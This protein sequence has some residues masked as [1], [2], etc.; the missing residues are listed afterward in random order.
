M[1]GPLARIA[2]SLL[3]ALLPLSPAAAPPD[4]LL[5]PPLVV[6]AG[7]AEPGQL[8]AKGDGAFEFRR[9]VSRLEEMRSA[10]YLA[11]GHGES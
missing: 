5:L 2:A 8:H 9:T 1:T 6:A 11:E 10:D 3:L 4:Q 7:D